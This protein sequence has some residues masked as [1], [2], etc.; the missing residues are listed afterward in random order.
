MKTLKEI[1]EADNITTLTKEE[2]NIRI[3]ER[4]RRIAELQKQ[5][6]ELGE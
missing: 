2:Q 4:Q 6:K 1:M 5:I 3:A